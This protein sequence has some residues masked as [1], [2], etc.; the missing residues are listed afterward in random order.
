MPV[1]CGEETGVGRVPAGFIGNCPTRGTVIDAKEMAAWM[2]EK[3]DQEGCLYQEDA[4]DYLLRSKASELLRIN[5]A[6][7]EV[8]GREVLGA[9][10]KLT[11]KTV[12][13]ARSERYWRHRVAEDPPGRETEL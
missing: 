9:F 12:V 13:W 6:G 1:V 10:L 7:N 11:R 4:A 3:V 8:L 5:S 2:A